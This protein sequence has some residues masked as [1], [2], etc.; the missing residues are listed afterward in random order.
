L[1]I[2]AR[3]KRSGE[4]RQDGDVGAKRNNNRLKI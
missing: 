2:E 4:W 3:R 1:E